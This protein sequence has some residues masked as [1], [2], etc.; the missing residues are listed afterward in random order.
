LDSTAAIGGDAV[1]GVFWLTFVSAPFN[2]KVGY[3][4]LVI[5]NWVEM[6]NQSEWV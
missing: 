6:V 5:F 1:G 4:L 3:W 2:R